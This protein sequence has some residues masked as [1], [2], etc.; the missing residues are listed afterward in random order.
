M[1]E[2]YLN[3]IF[4]NRT[5]KLYIT[6][7]LFYYILVGELCFSLFLCPLLVVL[8]MKKRELILK[9]IV[10]TLNT[11]QLLHYLK[12]IV[13]DIILSSLSLIKIIWSPENLEE[14]L[15][16]PKI[17]WIETSQ[18]TELGVA[19]LANSITI[20]P[21]TISIEIQENKILVHSINK[22]AVDNF[23]YTLDN[24]IKKL[25]G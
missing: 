13:H 4:S 2:S 7:F 24:I 18:K 14:D 22:D 1:I 23:D 9:E 16:S 8:I 10:L 3:K 20:T 12:T 6:L 19:L 11:S 25:V 15:I 5:I 21:G 17:K